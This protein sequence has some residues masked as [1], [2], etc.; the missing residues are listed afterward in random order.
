MSKRGVS[1]EEKK[2]RMLQLFYERAE[3]FQLKELEKIA[4]KE[5]GIV[6]NSV[7]DTIEKLVEDGLVDTDKIGGS[8]YFWAF[9]SKAIH[10][11]NRILKDLQQK[12]EDSNKKLKLIEETLSN[13]KNEDDDEQKR[14]GLLEELNDKEIELNA[15]QNKLRV[16]KENDPIKIK[17][18]ERKCEELKNAANRWTDNIFSMKSWCQRKFMVESKVL[19]K[20][21]GIPED[22]D[23][24]E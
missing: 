8:I 12:L 9:P 7:K 10:S 6:A 20:Q 2:A 17:A 5:K 14:S 11:R 3:C 21:F 24:I 16:C 1:A 4:P 13:S 19:N 23:Y 22:L 18:F 15:L